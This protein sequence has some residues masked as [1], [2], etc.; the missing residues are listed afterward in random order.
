MIKANLGEIAALGTALCWTVSG[1]AFESAGK[2]V[3]SLS[4]NYIR[5]VF[6]FIFI[7]TY[8]FFTREM[9]LPLDASTS[10]W[11]WLGISGFIGFFL[12]DL[13]LFQAYV[14]IGTRISLL[15]MALSPPISAFFGFIFL[16]EKLQ[17]IDLLGMSITVFGIAM[18]ILSKGEDEDRVKVAYSPQGLL[19]AFLGA[20]GQA[21]GLIFSKKGMGGSYHPI[22]ATQIRIIAAFISFTVLFLI[23]NK[24]K[25]LK[26]SFKD[27]KAIIGITIG[28][29][30]GPFI[31]V[32]LSLV[33]LQHT[34]AGV[35]TAISSIT[36]ITIIP[37]SILILKEKIKLK[38]ILGAIVTI[39]GV[40]I[41]FI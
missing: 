8:A 26:S 33:S 24:F 37:F 12:G 3:G 13:F 19:Y 7:S 30:F 38:E 2:R 18:V 25:E 29:I 20:L 35:S 16:G 22:A 41:L 34:Y 6:G 14:E 40:I 28:S 9:A 17:L 4:V 21:L 1:I 39:V 5:L 32:T 36:P 15:I 31:G 23:A 10:N 11:I 27:K